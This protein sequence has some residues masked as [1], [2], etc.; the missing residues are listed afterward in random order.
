MPIY[1]HALT[2]VKMQSISASIFIVLLLLSLPAKAIPLVDPKLPVAWD[3]AVASFVQ[4]YIALSGTS[5]E[6]DKQSSR[7]QNVPKI[8]FDLMEISTWSDAMAETLVGIS[9]GHESPERLPAL[10]KEIRELVDS[11]S[12]TFRAIDPAWKGP[13][14]YADF[15]KALD[16]LQDGRFD[17][18]DGRIWELM[19]GRDMKPDET[20]KLAFNFHTAAQDLIVI[21]RNLIREAN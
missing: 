20:R 1:F 12:S 3:Q 2:K 10:A 14:A 7:S 6:H 15:Q 17:F 11:L 21:S 8:V 19:S 9:T 16:Q 4:H 13:P 18:V 5:S